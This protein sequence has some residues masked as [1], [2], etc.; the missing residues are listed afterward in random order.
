MKKYFYRLLSDFGIYNIKHFLQKKSFKVLMF[1]RFVKNEHDNAISKKYINTHFF[2]S[3]L[4]YLS[5]KFNILTLK[6]CLIYRKKNGFFPVNS[7]VITIDDGYE[8]FYVNAYPI[9]KKYNLTATV[10][11][12]E[13][14]TSRYCCKGTKLDHLVL[15]HC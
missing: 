2:E 6:Q 4:S 3:Q 15:F 11:L 9:F 10:F 13:G 5:K 1:H 14:N 7:L 12:A 8:D